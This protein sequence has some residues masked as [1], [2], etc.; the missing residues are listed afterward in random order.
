MAIIKKHWLIIPFDK[1]EIKDR[2]NLIKYCSDD[3]PYYDRVI[4]IICGMGIGDATG[5][6][7]EFLDCIKFY[8][9]SFFE[10]ATQNWQGWPK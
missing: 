8:K 7:L 6:P 5:V 10:L 3:N 1:I 2:N 4:G 9:K